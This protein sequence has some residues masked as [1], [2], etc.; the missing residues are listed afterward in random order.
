MFIWAWRTNLS[1]SSSTLTPGLDWDEKQIV[2]QHKPSAER[3]SKMNQ[4]TSEFQYESIILFVLL[5]L[6]LI[7]IS[8]NA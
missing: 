2:F 5:V 7:V 3:N 4:K 8:T 1:P 6:E